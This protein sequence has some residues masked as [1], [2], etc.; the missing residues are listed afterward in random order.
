[1]NATDNCTCGS[2][3]MLNRNAPV[4]HVQIKTLSGFIDIC[5]CTHLQTEEDLN[6]K[7]MSANFGEKPLTH[8]TS[9]INNLGI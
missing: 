7:L 1:M 4:L 8:H 2:S 9:K 5:I 6:G 3:I